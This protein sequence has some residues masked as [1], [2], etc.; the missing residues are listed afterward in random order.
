MR[1]IAITTKRLQCRIKASPGH[2]LCHVHIPMMKRNPNLKTVHRVEQEVLERKT[3]EQEVVNFQTPHVTECQC[4]FTPETEAQHPL[5]SCTKMPNT[6][7]FCQD[8]IRGYINTHLAD[9]TASST[10]M[11][12]TSDQCKGVYPTTILQKILDADKFGQL[13]EQMQLMHVKQLAGTLDHFH[14]CPFCQRYGVQIK[15]INAV[16]EATCG[17]C[18]HIWCLKCRQESHSQQIPCERLR[19]LDPEFVRHKVEEFITS[20]L[21]HT[22]PS[23]HTKYIKDDGCNLM[24]C[25]QCKCYSCY[26][27]GIT[28]KP[29]RGTKYWH[30]QN[31]VH[32]DPNATCPLYC[33]ND[34]RNGNHIYN[35]AK[36]K[37]VC[38]R[39]FEANPTHDAQEMIRSCLID[40]GYEEHAIPASRWSFIRKYIQR[41]RCCY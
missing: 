37:D 8:C 16:R 35:T 34:F 21:M 28:L 39:I 32:A 41:L 4:C 15:N 25:P 11:S 5:V 13:N 23:C 18:Y 19:Q 38:K 24:T 7:R 27:C 10:C 3:E 26:L 29:K 9:G 36:L 31:H 2:V 14:I 33:N 12:H 6:H 20:A 17:V 40:L 1:C 30:F 22:C